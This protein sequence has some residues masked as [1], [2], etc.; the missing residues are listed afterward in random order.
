L[1]MVISVLIVLKLFY[2]YH[3]ALTY[4]INDNIP[5]FLFKTNLGTKPDA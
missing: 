5:A 1:F 2:S 4:R 3:F